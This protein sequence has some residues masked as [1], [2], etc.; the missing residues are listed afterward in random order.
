MV[1][2]NNKLNEELSHLAHLAMM[3]IDIAQAKI[4][5]LS[6]S[7]IGFD[8]SK[9]LNILYKELEA[10]KQLLMLYSKE[11]T[12]DELRIMIRRAEIEVIPPQSIKAY[13]NMNDKPL[14]K[15]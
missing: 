12:P 13:F 2:Q 14:D 5:R 1:K 9:P 15:V 6:T 11:R 8:L 3:D 7:R 4:H 10:S